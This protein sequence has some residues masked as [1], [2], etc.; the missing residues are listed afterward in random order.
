[1]E[2]TSLEENKIRSIPEAKDSK[3][4]GLIVGTISLVIVAGFFSFMI[5]VK[6]Y[7][8]PGNPLGIIVIISAAGLS[9]IGI[10]IY[11]IVSMFAGFKKERSLSFGL[12]LSLAMSATFFFSLFWIFGFKGL[13]S[14]I[15]SLPL[16]IIVAPYVLIDSWPVLLIGLILFVVWRIY[17]SKKVESSNQKI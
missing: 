14:I 15:S 10:L 16:A 1:M 2:N 7:E 12:V 9:M 11:S 6:N 5:D 13:V 8:G 4:R 3:G 17:R